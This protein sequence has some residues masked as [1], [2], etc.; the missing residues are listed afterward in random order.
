MRITATNTTNLMMITNYAE[1]HGLR[2]QTVYNYIHTKK[3]NFEGKILKIGK[4]LMLTKD[5]I[6]ELNLHTFRDYKPRKKTKTK[7]ETEKAVVYI[8]TDPSKLGEIMAQLN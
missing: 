6:D 3:Q 4:T 7:I 8:I 2:Y 5:A 1:E